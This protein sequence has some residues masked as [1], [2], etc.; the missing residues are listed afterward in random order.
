MS[1]R[2][3]DRVLH[4]PLER[5]WTD[6]PVDSTIVDEERRRPFDAQAIARRAIHG[7]CG[8]HRIVG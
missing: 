2:L 8:L 6:I 4:L 3:F 7:N 5:P 1:A